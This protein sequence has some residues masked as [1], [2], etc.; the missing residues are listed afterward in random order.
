MQGMLKNNFLILAVVIAAALF[1]RPSLSGKFA[2]SE[3][4]VLPGQVAEPWGFM[5]APL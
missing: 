3:V 4:T 1:S 2:G 5:M